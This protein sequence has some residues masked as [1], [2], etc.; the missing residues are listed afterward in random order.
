ML[1]SL[2]RCHIAQMYGNESTAKP[3]LDIG[4]EVGRRLWGRLQR[5]DTESVMDT[6]R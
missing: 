3:V 2:T 4:G 1:F 5:P 6:H